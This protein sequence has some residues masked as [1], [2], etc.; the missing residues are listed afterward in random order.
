MLGVLFF[1]T[2]RTAVRIRP[3]PPQETQ[4]SWVFFV[5]PFSRS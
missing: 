2:I 3:A 4:F 5:E 1:L